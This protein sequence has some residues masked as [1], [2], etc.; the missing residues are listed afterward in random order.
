MVKKKEKKRCQICNHLLGNPNDPRHLKSQKHIDA[1]NKKGKSQTY[2]VK[3]NKSTS[4]TIE[5]LQHP[6]TDNLFSHITSLE[7]RLRTLEQKFDNLIASNKKIRMKDFKDQL[8]KEYSHLNPFKDISGVDFEVLRRRICREL[9]IS[10][11]YFDDLI[12]DLKKDEH[13][14][15]VQ[16]GRGK[17]HIQ[18]KNY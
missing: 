4:P 8:I 10:N 11:D 16:S 15:T 12:Y 14:I 6:R 13:I 2:I 3:T 1:L 7:S 18:I 5:N 17:K 9:K